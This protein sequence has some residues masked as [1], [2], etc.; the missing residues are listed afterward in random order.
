LEFFEPRYDG[1]LDWYFVFTFGE[2]MYRDFYVRFQ[3][4]VKQQFLVAVSGVVLVF[5][6]G[7]PAA[8]QGRQGGMSIGSLQI[9]LTKSPRVQIAAALTAAGQYCVV[10]EGDAALALRLA[11]GQDLTSSQNDACG[12]SRSIGL[13][14]QKSGSVV[15]IAS[16]I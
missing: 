13:P 10:S 6:H 16:P 14:S 3:M 7:A 11:D 12:G 8:T 4:Y 2:A 9:F 5:S 1:V 15:V